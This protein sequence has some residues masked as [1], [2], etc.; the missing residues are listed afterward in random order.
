MIATIETSKP[1]TVSELLNVHCPGDHNLFIPIDTHFHT[2]PSY[3]SKAAW[4]Y[5]ARALGAKALN[6]PRWHCVARV[7]VIFP[8]ELYLLEI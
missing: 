3:Q 6:V 2:Q 5:L 7:H 8:L 4:E 1:V